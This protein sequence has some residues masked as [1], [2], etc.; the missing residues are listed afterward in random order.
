MRTR[1]HRVTAASCASLAAGLLLSSCTILLPQ[2]ARVPPD[3]ARAPHGNAGRPA[4]DSALGAF[5]GS[6]AENVPEIDQLQDWLG[7]T[8][9]RVGHTYLPGDTWQNIE[10]RPAFLRPWARWKQG[11][12]DRL[13][14]LNVPLLEGNENRVGDEEVRE[15]LRRAAGGEFDEHFRTLAHHLVDAG[16]PDTVL[17]PGWEMNGTTYTHRCAPDP[18]AWKAY[19]R[20]VVTVMREVPGQRF[21]FDFTPSR[22]R[23]AIGW[24][25]CYPGDDVVDILGMD[26]YDQPAGESFSDM[27]HEP[28]GLQAQVD[29]AAAHGKPVSYPEWG[30]FR[31][32]D[33]PGYVT[34]M[35]KWMDRHHPVY[36][37][38]TD[39]C[40]H[41]VWGCEENPASARA[42]RE[43]LFGR[44]QSSSPTTVP[45]PAAT[46]GARPE[47]TATPA[48]ATRPPHGRPAAGVRPAPRRC[49]ELRGWFS[50][51]L[52]RHRLC[53]RL[54]WLP[55]ADDRR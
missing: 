26:S 31:N 13:F 32:G 1:H 22:G 28:F 35:L 14:V 52:G 17:V 3:A 24:T 43:A 39:Y 9:L 36:Q 53:L 19:W 12:S 44:P 47:P 41:G 25:E 21:R 54:G 6:D 51:L 50:R 11:A 2:P 4:L 40:P 23:D 46:G 7:G 38:I 55:R 37:T 16:V 48:P 15:L 20:R 34:Q 5:V 33:N 18:E 30:L 29:F 10:G 8:D 27:V 49:L 42:Y 45:G